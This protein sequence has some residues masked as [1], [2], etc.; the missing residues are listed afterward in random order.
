MLREGALLEHGSKKPRMAS[1]SRAQ[2]L[3]FPFELKGRQGNRTPFFEG[4]SIF[5][6]GSADDS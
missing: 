6:K 5:P 2:V 4:V 3:S 1:P